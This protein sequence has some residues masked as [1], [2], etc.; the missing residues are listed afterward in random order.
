[1]KKVFNIE[2]D[3]AACALKCEEAIKKVEGVDA[4]QINFI[5]QKMTIE[6]ADVDAV[7][8]KALKAAKKVE[9]DFEI[10]E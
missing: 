8:K 2:V 6:A 5:T 4:C 9:P 10:V 3:C 1:M 7:L